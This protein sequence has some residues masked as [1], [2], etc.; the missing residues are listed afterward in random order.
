MLPCSSSGRNCLSDSTYGKLSTAMWGEL[1]GFL[2]CATLAGRLAGCMSELLVMLRRV[3]AAALH[4][5]MPS[6]T[7]TP[8]KQREV[9][10]SSTGY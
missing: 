9:K 5:E 3:L 7:K 10:L 2:T 1:L 6:G 4:P 8:K